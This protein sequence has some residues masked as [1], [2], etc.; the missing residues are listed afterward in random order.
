[1]RGQDARIYW[2]Y[3]LVGTVGAWTVTR[4]SPADPGT[5]TATVK[6]MDSFRASQRPLEC[7]VTHQHGEWRWP[8][9]TLQIEGTSLTAR[10]APK[11]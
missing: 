6:T 10:L 9:A 1:M 11:E 2:Q 3:Y 4:H 5:F 8:L 7:R